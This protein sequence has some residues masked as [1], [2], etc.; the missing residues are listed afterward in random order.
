MNVVYRI[1]RLG[2]VGL[3]ADCLVPSVRPDELL[4]AVSVGM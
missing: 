4:A 1:V 3:T 2:N